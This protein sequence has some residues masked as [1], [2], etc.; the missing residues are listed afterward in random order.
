MPKRTPSNYKSYK[1]NTN[2]KRASK[3]KKRKS[4]IKYILLGLIVLMLIILIGKKPILNAYYEY[5][6]SKPI[7]QEEPKIADGVTIMGIDVSGLNE[8]KAL[9]KIKKQFSELD[10]DYAYRVASDDNKYSFQYSF[11]DLGISYDIEG[12]VK[13]AV[14]FANPNLSDTWWRDYKIIENGNVDFSIL[15]Y[16]YG[17][18]KNKVK[19]MAS[20][21]D[22]PLKDASVVRENG[23]FVVTK[24]SVGYEVDQK[25]II[26][27]ILASI[28]A[29]EFEKDISFSVNE[30]K[31][32]HTS[33]DF[34][35][36]DHLIG[37]Y[38]NTYKRDDDNRVKN[39]QNACEK[40]NGVVVYP[41]DEFSTNERF[42]PCT[43]KNG[44]R[45]AGT[46][47]N[48]N[49]EDSVGGGMCQVSSALYMAVLEAELDVTE[50]HNHSIKVNYMPY[51]YDAALAGDYKDLKFKNDTDKPIYI[52]AYLTN[53]R[54]KV[55]IYG[56]EIHDSSR[57]IEF[58]SKHIATQEPE[59]PIKKSD[60]E[61][62]VGTEKVS[63]SALN[64]Q[65]YKLYK[66][67]YENDK[68]V[69]T[70]NIN[71]SIYVPRREVISVGTKEE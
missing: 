68:L 66:K 48:G 3:K 71:T 21:V 58:E 64:G 62:P 29:L 41:G 40:I 53:S 7:E 6:L 46:I 56:K 31:P 59:G 22:I 61:L 33:A 30:I 5:K 10:Y 55:N 34:D 43:E 11:E 38:S 65:T 70:I 28:K 36:I 51:A 35:E 20:D 14:S 69:D 60:N 37:T 45:M 32:K 42:N 18:I 1:T 47:V 15:K 44:W 57:K 19:S 39:L 13:S 26:N 24:S 16:N 50:R 25:Q 63:V 27:D 4:N 54:V 52:E 49:I 8:K 67:V 17:L 23:Q 2:K 12:A 9:I